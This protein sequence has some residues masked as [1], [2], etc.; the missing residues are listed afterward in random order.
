[1]TYGHAHGQGHAHGRAHAHVHIRYTWLKVRVILALYVR[2][3]HPDEFLC[4]AFDHPAMA[5]RTDLTAWTVHEVKEWAEEQWPGSEV[6]EK[7]AGMV[8][9]NAL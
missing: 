5:T 8:D 2:T 7:M 3:S 6:A 4:V 9:I 1:M